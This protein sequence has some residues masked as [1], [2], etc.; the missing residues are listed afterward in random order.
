[1][2][3][4]PI[5]ELHKVS[6]SYD[7]AAVVRDVS[8]QIQPGEI[9][10][11][12]GPSGSGKTTLLNTVAGLQSLD[13]GRVTLRGEAASDGTIFLPPESRRLSM[14]FQDLALLPHRTALENVRL[15]VKYMARSQGQKL[16]KSEQIKRAEAALDLADMLP[17]AQRYPH[18]LSGGQQQRVAFARALAP[19]PDLILFDEPFSSLDKELRDRLAT[20]LRQTLKATNTAA[21]IVTHDQQEAFA[22]ADKVA[23]LRDG[24]LEQWDSPWQ[25]Y[26][27]P[28]SEFV[29]EFIGKGCWVEGIVKA[30]KITTALGD[31]PLS[32][33]FA[34]GTALKFRLRPDQLL[35]DEQGELS[36]RLVEIAFHGE[37]AL[38]TVEL[39]NQQRVYCSYPSHTPHQQGE[40]LRLSI[41]NR[42]VLAFP[43]Q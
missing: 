9:V 7:G 42:S 5:L 40:I 36:G 43:L 18:E 23:V 8:L 39:D 25:L 20:E 16:A 37:D 22:V 2:A 27:M 15:A 35:P 17:F 29:A 6:A 32:Q 38:Y 19:K 28:G 14:V 26:H 21:I 13:A 31:L 41:I 11:L 10:C 30:G 12:L 1:M 3:N 24:Q 4:A 33:P 34:D